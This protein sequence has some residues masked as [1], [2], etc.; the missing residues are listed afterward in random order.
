MWWW[1]CIFFF[2][3]K[4]LLLFSLS[5]TSD[6]LWPHGLQHAR[7]PCPSLPPR[8]CSNSCLLSWWCHPTILSSVV[9]PPSLQSFPVSGSFPVSQL[10]ASG[11]QSTGASASACIPP[12]TIHTS[13][14]QHSFNE[15]K[16]VTVSPK[17]IKNLTEVFFFLVRSKCNHLSKN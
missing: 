1:L 15:K 16:K 11:G 5:G 3:S 8:A 4:Y 9:S 17:L 13:K 12:L 2:N 7:F 10:F 6:C 14:T